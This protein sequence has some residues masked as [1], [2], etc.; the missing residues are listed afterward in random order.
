MERSLWSDGRSDTGGDVCAD[1]N[2]DQSQAL[3]FHGEIEEDVVL[4]LFVDDSGVSDTEPS[5]V[6]KIQLPLFVEDSGESDTEPSVVP[7]IQQ[8]YQ[9][10]RLPTQRNSS[11]SEAAAGSVPTQSQQQGEN[12]GLRVSPVATEGRLYPG[13]S[14]RLFQQNLQ[15]S[16]QRWAGQ[17]WILVY[18]SGRPLTCEEILQIIPPP[19]L[20]SGFEGGPL[21][22]IDRLTPTVEMPQDLSRDR[23]W[24]IFGRYEQTTD[25]WKRLHAALKRATE[26]NRLSELR[27]LLREEPSRLTAPHPT[28]PPLVTESVPATRPRSARIAAAAAAVKAGEDSDEEETTRRDAKK[29]KS[30]NIV[31]RYVVEV[32]TTELFVRA[33]FVR[34]VA[35]AMPWALWRL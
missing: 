29:Q 28:D 1:R 7:E 27:R 14:N 23:L 18:L 22:A 30:V 8:Q 9:P 16:L 35:S 10:Q 26:E 34:T 15:R 31:E 17:I 20:P 2:G 12:E 19:V 21:K 11:S 13:S 24:E 32:D 4:P 3:I 5:V 6:P 33:D 25:L